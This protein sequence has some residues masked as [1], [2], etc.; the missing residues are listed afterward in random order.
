MDFLQFVAFIFAVFT[1]AAG[2]TPATP[3]NPTI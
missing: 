1:P 3:R 2:I